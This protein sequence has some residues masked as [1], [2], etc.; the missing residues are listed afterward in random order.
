MF[1]MQLIKRRLFHS[2]RIYWFNNTILLFIEGISHA[3][4]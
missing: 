3:S 1:D 4:N 2:L